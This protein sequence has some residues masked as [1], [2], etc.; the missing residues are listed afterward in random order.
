MEKGISRGSSPLRSLTPNA[1]SVLRT[2]GVPC[3][4]QPPSEK[5]LTWHL[6]NSPI[7]RSTGASL[8]L[9]PLSMA[10]C[11]WGPERTPLSTAR[12]CI[13]S[14]FQQVSHKRGGPKLGTFHTSKEALDPIPPRI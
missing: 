1:P 10:L 6:C 12:D 2:G 13:A 14:K 9:S 5:R 3:P 11:P 7:P 8:A 4:S